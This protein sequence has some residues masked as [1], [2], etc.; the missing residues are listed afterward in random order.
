MESMR[1]VKRWIGVGGTVTSL[2]SMLQELE[3]YD[4][5]KVQDYVI[6]LEDVSEILEKLSQMS[7]DDKSHMKGLLPSRADII[8]AGVKALVS[9]INNK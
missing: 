4:S 1:N 6:H 8:V 5:S 9:A 3:V 2:A 7:Y